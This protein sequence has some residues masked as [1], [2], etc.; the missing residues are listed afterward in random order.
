MGKKCVVAGCSNKHS[1]GVSLFLFPADENLRRQWTKQV[2]RTRA[3]WKGPTENSCLCSNHFTEDCFD[4]SSLTAS[5]LGLKRKL[6][7]K[8]NAIPTVFIRSL[9]SSKSS[10]GEAPKKKKRPS[11]AYEKRERKRVRKSSDINYY[12]YYIYIYIYIYNIYIVIYIYIYI[13]L[14]YII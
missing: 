12:I 4:P 14:L 8:P 3:C 1:D 13:L 5:R 6:L 10:S 2:Q 7:L 11:S 9:V